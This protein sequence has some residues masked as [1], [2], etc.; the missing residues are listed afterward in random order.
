[1]QS[2]R[3]DIDRDVVASEELLP[4]KSQRS[5]SPWVALDPLRRGAPQVYGTSIDG[6]LIY[7]SETAKGYIALTTAHHEK[8]G[9]KVELFEVPGQDRKGVV[10]AAPLGDWM[11]GRIHTNERALAQM[12]T[13]SDRGVSRLET[14]L[15]DDFDRHGASITNMVQ[16]M[17]M[18]PIP[19]G[20]QIHTG[21]VWQ[22]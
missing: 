6:R 18:P 11:R 3:G 9:D 16:M 4:G 13:R 21:A 19:K 15:R 8:R 20:Q 22:R 5:F 7:A 17:A 14:L 10:A 1:L 12:A 2:L